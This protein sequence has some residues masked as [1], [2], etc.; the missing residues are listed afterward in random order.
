MESRA[1]KR[2][3]KFIAETEYK[4]IPEE[5]RQVAKKAILDWAGVTIAGSGEPVAQ[6]ATRYAKRLSAIGEAGVIGGAF[7][8]SAKLAAWVN[9]ASGHALDYDDTFPDSVGYNFHPTAPVLPAVLALGERGDSPGTDVIAAYTVGIEV[10]SRTGA[11]IG[12]YNSEAGW[13][14]TSILGTI[15]AVAASAN[16]LKLNSRQAGMA[17]GIAGSLA[18]GLRQNF[19]TMT[20]PLHAGNAAKNGVV[21]A[22]LAQEGFTANE[23]IMEGNSGFCSIF[24]GGKVKGL[25][26]SEQDLGENWHIVSP[27]IS[28]KAY[29]CC[30]STHSSIDASLYLR[31]VVGLDPNQVAEIICKTSPQHPQIARF[32]RPKNGNEGKFSIPYCIALALLKGKVS[33]E[34]FTDEKVADAK[35]QALLSK[36]D[37][38]YPA[39]YKKSPFSLTQ[40]VVVK[41]DSGA[42]YSHRVEV[43][44]GDP[45][46]PMTS[47]ELSTKLR[48]CARLSLPKEIIERLI[49]TITKLERLDNVTRLMDMMTYKTTR[50]EE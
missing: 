12:S 26:N 49:E 17:L 45:E 19:G 41:L 37:Y 44:K 46:N 15:G 33:L 4:N 10:E 29:P 1:T 27:G 35:V 23:D 20:K 21:A 5:A 31:N 38:L 9:G 40:E 28:F 3:A 16:I 7:R 14:P 32:H 13:H 43:P 2:I 30:R 8:T 47:E 25:G 34:D 24:S 48:D 6:I 50:P 36:V 18:G 42:E 22:L 11:A 39:E